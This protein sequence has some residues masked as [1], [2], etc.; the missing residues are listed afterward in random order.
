M[1][2][3]VLDCERGLRALQQGDHG[4]VNRQFQ[5]GHRILDHLSATL[6]TEDWEAGLGLMSLYDWVTRQLIKAN[7]DRDQGA[8][9][10]ALTRS[11]DLLDMWRSVALGAALSAPPETTSQESR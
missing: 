6:D 5:H 4:E 7:I 3:L 8:A 10:E 11:K 9:L 1:E 2:R